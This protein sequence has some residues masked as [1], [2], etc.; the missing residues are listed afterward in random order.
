MS[1]DALVNTG[2]SESSLSDWVLSVLGATELSDEVLT[3][4]VGTDIPVND[5][6]DSERL[7]FALYFIVTRRLFEGKTLSLRQKMFVKGL[8]H[9]INSM[10]LTL[11][12]KSSF[13]SIW[14]T[15]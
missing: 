5:L 7:T 9:D 12:I 15:S 1:S 14:D 4:L 13:Q 2:S 6:D 10:M 3:K 8:Q 11:E